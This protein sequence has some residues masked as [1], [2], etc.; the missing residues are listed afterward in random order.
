ML[1]KASCLS[2]NSV[3]STVETIRRMIDQSPTVNRVLAD[4]GD[5]SGTGRIATRE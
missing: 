4:L 3:T 5:V 2:F 1:P